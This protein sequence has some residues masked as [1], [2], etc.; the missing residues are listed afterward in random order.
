MS[1]QD[2]LLLYRGERDSFGLR[3]FDPALVARH[4][5]RDLAIVVGAILRAAFA[6]KPVISG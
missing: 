4:A 3:R 5:S 2:R 6:R 1:F